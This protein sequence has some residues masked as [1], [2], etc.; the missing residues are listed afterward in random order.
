MNQSHRQVK[1]S[2]EEVKH[3][4]DLARLDMD[5][6]SIEMFSQQIGNILHYIDTLNGVDTENTIPTSHAVFLPNAFRDDEVKD[7]LDRNLA[8]ANAPEKENGN[9]I[10]PK[11]IG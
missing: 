7:H 6:N 4:A 8:L 1:I 9:F 2:K 5:K 10:V 11:V 3:V